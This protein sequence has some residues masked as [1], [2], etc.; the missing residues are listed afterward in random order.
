ME[1][2]KK[3]QN[4]VDQILNFISLESFIL[5][6]HCNE[7]ECEMIEINV[8]GKDQVGGSAL[9][10]WETDENILYFAE[11]VAFRV[12]LSEPVLIGLK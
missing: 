6:A 2:Q 1:I 3:I 9:F 5:D 10:E 7:K 4:L 11:E 8:F 12:R